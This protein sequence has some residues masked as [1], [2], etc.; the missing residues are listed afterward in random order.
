[1]SWA[2]EVLVS[3]E[4]SGNALRF[5]TEAEAAEWARALLWRWFVPTDSRAVPSEDPVSDALVE[6]VL[7]RVGV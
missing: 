6:G 2:P 3:G 7:Q 4:W 5:E 1:M